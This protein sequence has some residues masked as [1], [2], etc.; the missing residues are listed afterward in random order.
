MKKPVSSSVLGAVYRSSEYL[1]PDSKG[2]AHADVLKIN[3]EA[4]HSELIELAGV[5]HDSAA[6]AKLGDASTRIA[7][8]FLLKR[9]KIEDFSM[10][11]IGPGENTLPRHRMSHAFGPAGYNI[12][13]TVEKALID[14]GDA[15][16]EVPY[17]AC[18]ERERI[19]APDIV[20][21]LGKAVRNKRIPRRFLEPEGSLFLSF[22]DGAGGES[23]DLTLFDVLTGD[24]YFKAAAGD[25]DELSEFQRFVRTNPLTS[26]MEDRLGAFFHAPITVGVRD[27]MRW[28]MGSRHPD[29]G[30][31]KA[32]ETI[33]KCFAA[34]PTENFLP[35][36][37]TYY[38]PD[39]S[40][41]DDQLARVFGTNDRVVAL[42]AADMEDALK[43]KGFLGLER[44]LVLRL[45]RQILNFHH[46]YPVYEVEPYQGLVS[47]T[48]L[49]LAARVVANLALIYSGLDL[50]EKKNT[51]LEWLARRPGD[52]LVLAS[53]MEADD[54]QRFFGAA[55]QALSRY[56]SRG[57]MRDEQGNVWS[58]HRI[59]RTFY[60]FQEYAEYPT[61]AKGR[62][63]DTFNLEDLQK[64]PYKSLLR[65]LPELSEKLTVFFTLVYRYYQDTGFV[66]DLRPKHAGRDIFVL[67][68]W[69]HVSENLLITLWRD[70]A[71][72]L[73]ADLSFVDNKDHFKE[74]RRV[75]DRQVP[76]GIA[77]HALR[78]TGP[79]VE[80]AMLRSVGIFTD[81][82]ENNW[83]GGIRRPASLFDK[84]A[85][86]GLDIANEVIHQ[87]LEHAFDNTKVAAEDLV[88][89]FFAGLRRWL[90]L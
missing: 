55:E 79:V 43:S 60:S 72:E 19:F 37:V 13:P 75:E 82:A 89:D 30:W 87:G 65:T 39:Y 41:T 50:P 44:D 90:K 69:G 12:L 23:T 58:Y 5:D 78:L 18:G 47:V 34:H 59:P 46:D 15:G 71:G 74:Y 3:P 17:F 54:Q 33:L 35:P 32:R 51:H 31:E 63:E 4:L 57:G 49:R 45:A 83:S 61:A 24:P 52:L 25:I 22:I 10:Q 38:A 64:P 16:R 11:I 6:S 14:A 88:D 2:G 27:T 29:I 1:Q 77:R 26:S 9:G 67:G 73:H 68:I 66:P 81:I 28:A 85:T 80:P 36:E 76:V 70:T 40:L 53:R 42:F 86:K 62:I 56:I 8:R 20:A 21:Q 7:R 84:Y 48:T